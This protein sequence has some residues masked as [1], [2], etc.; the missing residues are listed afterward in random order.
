MLVT[1]TECL[2][3]SRNQGGTA[4]ILRPSLYEGRSFLVSL[5]KCYIAGIKQE[6][7]KKT[8]KETLQ[9]NQRRSDE[10]DSGF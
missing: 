4:D 9:K 10:A 6:E 7:R 1:H 2:L 3:I 8:M 5:K